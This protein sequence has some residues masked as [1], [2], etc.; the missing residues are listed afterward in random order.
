MLILFLSS[1]IFRNSHSLPLKIFSAQFWGFD[2]W[3]Y[4][5]STL[6]GIQSLP[7]FFSYF[8]IEFHLFRLGWFAFFSSIIFLFH[9]PLSLSIVHSFFVSILKTFYSESLFTL[10]NLIMENWIQACAVSH[11]FNSS[12]GYFFFMLCISNCRILY[13]RTN[14]NYL[15]VPIEY[16]ID[17]VLSIQIQTMLLLLFRAFFSG[18]FAIDMFSFRYKRVY[19]F[20]LFFFP[21]L[22]IFRKNIE[23]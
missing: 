18:H 10:Y 12:F 6:F 17:H 8:V 16:W 21:I 13:G 1:S 5:N 3:F 19:F 2:D 23:F 22:C 4:H 15:L 20:F 7:R 9:L 11:H 14:M